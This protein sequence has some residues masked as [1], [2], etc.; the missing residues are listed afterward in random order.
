MEVTPVQTRHDLAAQLYNL[1]GQE[2]T[3]KYKDCE[4]K[5]IEY[6]IKFKEYQQHKI[7]KNIYNFVENNTPERYKTLLNGPTS[8]VYWTWK[9]TIINEIIKN[10]PAGENLVKLQELLTKEKSISEKLLGYYERLYQG[11]R[12]S[13]FN[14]INI[15]SL[16]ENLRKTVDSNRAFIENC[17]NKVKKAVK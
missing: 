5:L 12:C 16:Y 15:S 14:D 13:H 17:A 7:G 1:R 3:Q 10:N 9:S 6:K 4:R 2:D 8:K 11:K